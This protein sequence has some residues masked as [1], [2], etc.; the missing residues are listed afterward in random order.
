[1]KNIKYRNLFAFISLIVFLLSYSGVSAQ[2]ATKEKKW[3]YLID[4][5]LMFPYMDGEVGIGESL[6]IPVNAT[7][8]DVFSKLQMGAMLY[9]EAKT[10]KYALTS[11]LVYMNLKQDVTANK[12]I[13]SGNIGAKQM[14]WEVAGLARLFPFMEVGLGGRINYLQTSVDIERN[15]FHSGTESISGSYNNTWFDPIFITRFSTN[16]KDKWLFQL[17]ADFGGFG[18]GSSITY[19]LQGYVGYRFNKV[20]Q[21]TAGYRIYSTDYKTG[22]D[23]NEFRFN[24]KEFGPVVRLGFNF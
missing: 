1:M 22:E 13:N 4:A 11:D 9:F 5:Y 7:A 24:M 16:I 6:S 17:R 14:I 8:G 15:V 2:E 20:F 18:I 3:H 10:D 21:L 23:E 19:Q 12:L